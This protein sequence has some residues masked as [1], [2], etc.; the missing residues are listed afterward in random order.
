MATDTSN[1][2]LILP[3]VN[4]PVDEDLWGGYLN[5]NFEELDVIIPST[6][7]S[8]GTATTLNKSYFNQF[9][10]INTTSGTV[11][12]TLGTASTYYNGWEAAFSITAGTFPAV[13]SSVS[14]INGTTSVTLNNQYQTVTLVT[15]ASTFYKKISTTPENGSITTA[16]LA[17][18]AVT[19]PKMANG[20][21]GALIS[22]GTSGAPTSIS[23]G[24]VD[25]V[26]TST[27]T[28]TVPGWVRP[29]FI[30]YFN[31]SPQTISTPNS[32]TL[33]T[34]PHGLGITPT[35]WQ[36]YYECLIAD[37]NYSPGDI[38][39]AQTMN[40]ASGN[41]GFTSYADATNVYIVQGITLY[42]NNRSSGILQAL[43]ANSWAF[44]VRAW[45]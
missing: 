41:S 30:D 22:Y 5:D 34:F 14:S 11:N 3:A 44:R 40:Q 31:S 32:Y 2:Q 7:V 35:V 29:P 12:I 10:K 21:T 4:D 24:T 17:D 26:L 43:T 39:L 28:T 23:A 19:L 13:I 15:D 37:F 6:A 1:L 38:L 36:V 8:I 16:M 9:V 27:G 33:F 45:V 20:T 25:Y 42:I 18:G